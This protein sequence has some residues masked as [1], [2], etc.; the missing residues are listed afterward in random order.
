MDQRYHVCHRQTTWEAAC[1]Y[2]LR[3]AWAKS[4]EAVVLQKGLPPRHCRRKCFHR[5]QN[6]NS[7]AVEDQCPTRTDFVTPIAE[8]PLIRSTPNIFQFDMI[9]H[10]N[11]QPQS[12]TC[13]RVM[14]R[15]LLDTGAKLNMVAAA[16]LRG[17]ELPVGGEPC[18][19]RSIAGNSRIVGQTALRFHFLQDVETEGVEST[20]EE[21]FNVLD[22]NEQPLFDFILGQE[23]ISRHLLKFFELT[24]SKSSAHHLH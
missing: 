13:R 2:R 16:A 9:V 15:V 11:Q 17:I 6:L 24:S 7:P 21:E 10:V 14:R 19:I 22:G 12:R 4:F 23:W 20:F 1:L 3:A 8:L 18:E 5:R